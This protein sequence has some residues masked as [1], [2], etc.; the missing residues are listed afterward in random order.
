M[1]IQ[2][3]SISEIERL[4]G[5]LS[6]DVLILKNNYNREQIIRWRRLANLGDVYLNT[7]LK[8]IHY[9]LSDSFSKDSDR[10][11][12]RKHLEEVARHL[13]IDRRNYLG[14]PGETIEAIIAGIYQHS[15]QGEAKRFVYECVMDKQI[16]LPNERVPWP[17]GG[18]RY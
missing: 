1:S 13:G 4:T 15:R 2:T 3:W 17:D 14:H 9:E 12:S 16:K 6:N 10:L 8:E 7:L 11:K 5:G 18:Y